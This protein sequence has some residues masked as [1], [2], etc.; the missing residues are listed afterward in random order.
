MKTIPGKTLILIG[1]LITLTVVLLGLAIFAS[2]N[3]KSATTQI[4]PSPTV[5]KTASI[6]FMPSALDISLPT[7]SSATVD[8]VA[9]TNGAPITG[10]QVEVK[11]DPTVITNVKL[12]PPTAT[13]L[14]GAV[15]NYVTLFSD[16]KALGKASFA[17]AIQPNGTPVNGTGSIGQISF[18][19]I[20]N[21]KPET[22][23]IFGTGTVVTSKTTQ[24]SVLESTTPLTIKLQ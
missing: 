15:G 20:K 2:G 14:F 11:Y 7:T 21:L 1:F 10:A 3:K 12:L 5:I 4:V 13:S 23:M 24:S 6:A 16:A 9:N 8:I 22:Q 18:T 19:V 17:V